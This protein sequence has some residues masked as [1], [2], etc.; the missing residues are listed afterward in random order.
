MEFT[1]AIAYIILI[2]KINLAFFLSVIC[3]H[4]CSYR[5]HLVFFVG[6]G[7]HVIWNYKY[8]HSNACSTLFMTLQASGIKVSILQTLQ[9]LL[10]LK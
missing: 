6:K 8:I 5:L 4:N 3:L 9:N 7:M 1:N 2:G 10:T